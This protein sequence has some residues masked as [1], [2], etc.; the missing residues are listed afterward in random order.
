M[1]ADET[2]PRAVP[3]EASNRIPFGIIATNLTLSGLWI[4]VNLGRTAEFITKSAVK[5]ECVNGTREAV[6]KM[7][8]N[9]HILTQK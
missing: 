9:N 7:K 1:R 2:A 5:L 8:T 6:P 4:A 3:K